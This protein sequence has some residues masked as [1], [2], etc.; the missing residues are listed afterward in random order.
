MDAAEI[1]HVLHS[2]NVDLLYHV[3]ERTFLSPFFACWIPLIAIGQSAPKFFLWSS[4]FL[5]FVIVRTLVQWSSQAWR[6]QRWGS[7]QI[8]W[9]EQIVVITG[10]SDGLGRV[11]VETLL[12]KHITV[13][14]LDIKS[15]G[16]IEEEDVTFYQC[17]VSDPRAVELVARRIREEVGTPTILVNNAG[18]VCPKPILEMEANDIQKTFGVNVLSHFYL[19]KEFLPDMIKSKSGHIVTIASILG[20]IGVAKLSDYCASKAA[21]ILLHQSLRQELNSIYKAH[22]VHTTL[23]CPGFMTTKMFE[24]TKTWN[25]FLFPKLSPHELMK[26][27]IQSIDN[28]DSNEIYVPLYTKFNFIFNLSDFFLFPSWLT[29]FLH[30]FVGSNEAYG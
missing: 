5:I 28:Q 3:T 9:S 4:I 19:I 26:K 18:I 16:D 29:S 24:N 10:G 12:L 27:I 13:V 20:H 11:L 23:V 7:G 30:W 17:D 14:V 6:N 2:I 22:D 15:Y 25:E 21:A 8:D 1:R